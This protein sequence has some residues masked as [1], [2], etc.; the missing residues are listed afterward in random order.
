VDAGLRSA[1]GRWGLALDP[2]AFA[3]GA[4]DM[5]DLLARCPAAVTLARGEHDPMNTDEQLARL[6]APARTLAGLGHNAHVESP[7]RCAELLEPYA[8]P[9]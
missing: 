7:D 5:A 1:D 9:G 6:G 8:T 4:P 3:V 2:R